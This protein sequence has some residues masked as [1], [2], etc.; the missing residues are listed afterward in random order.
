MIFDFRH[1]TIGL[2]FKQN[3][4]RKKDA[5]RIISLCRAPFNIKLF[6]FIPAIYMARIIYIILLKLVV[7]I[8]ITLKVGY[9]NIIAVLC[10]MFIQR[11][12]Q[13]LFSFKTNYSFHFLATLKNNQCGDA[14]NTKI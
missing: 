3:Q 9:V 1:L 4:A 10:D 14:D 8:L 5:L 6:F 2:R 7:F 13:F 12:L 11:R